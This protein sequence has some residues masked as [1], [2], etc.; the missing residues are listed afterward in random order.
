MC[1]SVNLYV[2]IWANKECMYTRMCVKYVH[3]CIRVSTCVC[4]WVQGC[5]QA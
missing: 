1:K 3:V 2:P 4:M 5:T